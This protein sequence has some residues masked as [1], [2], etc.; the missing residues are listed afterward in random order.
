MIKPKKM[1]TGARRAD[2]GTSG[3]EDDLECLL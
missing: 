2:P 3:D 1:A